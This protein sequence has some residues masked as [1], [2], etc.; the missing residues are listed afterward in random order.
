MPYRIRG[1]RPA[2]VGYEQRVEIRSQDRADPLCG[3]PGDFPAREHALRRT[4]G[5]SCGSEE[6][7]TRCEALRRQLPD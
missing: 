4:L 6:R 2:L 3:V 1:E 5:N 7:L